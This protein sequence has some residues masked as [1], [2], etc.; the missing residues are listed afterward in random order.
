MVVLFLILII[1][2]VPLLIG[3]R[4]VHPD[5]LVLAKVGVRRL[6][7]RRHLISHVVRHIIPGEMLLVV[8]CAALVII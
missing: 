8:H 5:H 7:R 4:R 3:L 1:K 6:G 2:A